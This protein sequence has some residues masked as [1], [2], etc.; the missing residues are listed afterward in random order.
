MKRITRPNSSNDTL[1]DKIEA[2]KSRQTSKLSS[3]SKKPISLAR[4]LALLQIQRPGLFLWTFVIITILM[5]PGI[6]QL[7]GNVEPSLE[8]VLPQDLEEIR[9]MNYLRGEFGVDMVYV[10]IH[11]NDGTQD[12]RNL[13]YIEYINTLTQNFQ[14]REYVVGVQSISN[15]I[16][17]VQEQQGLTT[18]PNSKYEIDEIFNTHPTINDYTDYSYS[19]SVIALQTTV[20][21]SAQAIKTLIESLEEDIELS[22]Y[23]NPGT[24]SQ[25]T[26]FSAIDYVTFSVIMTD[27]LLITFVSMAIISMIVWIT[28]KS[29]VRGMLPMLV[30]MVALIWTMGIVGYLS[31]TITVVS[32][33]AAAMIM[34]LGIDFGIHLIQ[35]YFRKREEDLLNAQESIIQV[36]E[37]LLRALIGASLTTMAGFLAL[38]F[39][40]LP[41]MQMLGGILALGIFTTLIGAVFLL[42]VVIYLYDRNNVY[43]K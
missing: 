7:V 27:F 34:G 17:Q 38:L 1:N 29:F 14:T 43:T 30:V 26:G 39:G 2:S 31:W 33:V 24:T 13:D 37:E 3:S 28:F 20:G 18:L 8:K 41:A 32:M 22:D 9:T 16:L 35:T 19:F 23:K 15:Q 11:T 21:A 36:V 25:I 10:L 12:I 40:V 6:V 42:P 5:I 4:R